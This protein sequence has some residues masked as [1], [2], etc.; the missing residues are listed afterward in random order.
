MEN[1]TLWKKTAGGGLG[2]SPLMALGQ[3]GNQKTTSLQV[4]YS[5]K[6][7]VLLIAKDIW[8]LQTNKLQ[9]AS[10]GIKDDQFLVHFHAV[11]HHL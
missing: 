3:A 7:R 4:R 9:G 6:V 5:S 1:L 10:A 2:G 8:R 11:L